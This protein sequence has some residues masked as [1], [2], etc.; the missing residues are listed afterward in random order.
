MKR[1]RIGACLVVAVLVL[2]V[3][4]TALSASYAGSSTAPP[5]AALVNPAGLATF[6]VAFNETGLPVSSTW[7]VTLNGT[8]LNGLAGSDIVFSEPNGTYDYS[9]AGPSGYK[10]LSPSATG[11]VRVQGSPD[12]VT[13]PSIAAGENPGDVAYDNANGDIYVT[14]FLGGNVTVINATTNEVT[15]PL[16]GISVGT[17]PYAIAYDPASGYVYVTH[18][19]GDDNLTVIDGA[20]QSTVG[21]IRV[22]SFPYDIAYDSANGYLYVP[23]EGGSDN[24]TVVNGAD[25]SVV[26]SIGDG[27]NPV[28]DVY[29][30]ANDYVYVANL[31][32]DNVTVI[33]AATD[34]VVVPSITAGSYPDAIGYDAA[35]GDIYVANSGDNTVTII[36]ATSNSVVVPDLSV[37]GGP[38]GFAYDPTNGYVYVANGDLANLTVID[39]ATNTVVASIGVGVEPSLLIY[40]SSSGDIYVANYGSNNVTVVSGNGLL[41]STWGRSAV[42][43]PTTYSLTFTE[44][45]LP[46]GT[47]WSVTFNG[48]TES[49]TSSSIAFTE[50]N[51]TY[52]F[53]VGAVAGYTVSPGSGSL[54]VEG[55]ALSEPITY[56]AVPPPPVTSV[57]IEANSASYTGSAPI[58]LSGSVS[59]APAVGTSAFV[60]VTNPVGTTVQVS[61]DPLN[62]V[63]EF[64][65]NFT[66]G[67]P[68]WVSGTYVVNATWAPSLG[69]SVYY[70]TTTFAYVSITTNE[71]TFSETGLTTGLSWSVTLNGSTE[72]AAAGSDITFSEANGA[73]A[74]EIPAVANYTVSP[75]SGTVTVDGAGVTVNVTF[76][77]PLDRTWDLAAPLSTTT[78]DGMEV[79]NATWMSYAAVPLTGIVWWEAVNSTGHTVEITAASMTLGSLA[80]GSAYFGLS[81]LAPGAYTI[82]VFVTTTQGVPISLTAS[83]GVTVT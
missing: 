54:T 7:S 40:V 15:A 58:Y 25:N 21:S 19:G 82:E 37:G 39:G 50:A 36:N 83:L 71:V 32:G 3:G 49:S 18:L 46:D 26:G 6:P 60:K 29:D 66:A 38:D 8:T 35:N 65:D 45:G 78:L 34:T 73:Y 24:V 44:S 76:T 69:G 63:G 22:G 5:R 2:M 30:P 81:T 27:Y 51:G 48:S 10:L 33:N 12:S 56:T 9:L 1:S 77:L 43:P 28:A 31:G 79:V 64:W 11:T 13:V 61:S 68:N 16:A 23:N 20:T 42:I 72:V 47:G 67:G 57:Q 74:F 75:S 52:S 62:A 17:Y 55:A 41:V 70:N 4:A 59:P 14:N 53:S 80:C